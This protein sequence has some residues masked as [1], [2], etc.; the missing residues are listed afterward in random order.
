MS[1][2]PDGPD[3]FVLGSCWE[4]TVLKWWQTDRHKMEAEG[5]SDG[6]GEERDGIMFPHVGWKMKFNIL[7]EIV[8]SHLPVCLD[9]SW[10]L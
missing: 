10:T 9:V 8:S 1:F 7:H 3:C 4:A 5:R 6:V 2:S